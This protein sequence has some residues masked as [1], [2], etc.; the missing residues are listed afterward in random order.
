MA[1]NAPAPVLFPLVPPHLV[2][3]RSVEMPEVNYIPKPFV[4]PSTPKQ[5]LPTF[6]HV[7]VAFTIGLLKAFFLPLE[8]LAM[9]DTPQ[10]APPRG[11]RDADPDA[12]PFTR[13]SKEYIVKT[14]LRENFVF[15]YIRLMAFR[16]ASIWAVYKAVVVIAERAKVLSENPS[17]L[18]SLG[19]VRD[20]VVILGL[21]AFVLYV[22][23]NA[24][25][26]ERE[27]GMRRAHR[28]RVRK[29][30]GL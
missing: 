19:F 24:E 15:N 8:P 6:V 14:S 25:Q 23:A 4:M 11:R 7:V 3:R 12:K 28:E 21:A 22:A 2:L 5:W 20:V 16:L 9:D 1:Q 17:V 27:L 26:I 13:Y 30:Y 18:P 29:A 10:P